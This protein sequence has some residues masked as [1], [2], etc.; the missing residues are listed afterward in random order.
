M[1]LAVIL[2]VLRLLILV[3]IAT[4][5]RESSS[6]V[7]ILKTIEVIKKAKDKDRDIEITL[8]NNVSLKRLIKVI[9]LLK[10]NRDL[11]KLKEYLN[12]V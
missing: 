3:K 9:P 7:I 10:F 11:S 5:E 2:W 12:K 1:R 6:R 8:N 4:E